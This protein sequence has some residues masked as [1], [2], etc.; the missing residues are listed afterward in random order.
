MTS[1]GVAFAA[2]EGLLVADF[3]ATSCFASLA[4][5]ATCPIGRSAVA[6][7]VL[8][9][10]AMVAVP[11]WLAWLMFASVVCRNGSWCT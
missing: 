11:C 9:V 5:F 8:A 7:V 4:C 6:A 1:A 3:V 10:C 2:F